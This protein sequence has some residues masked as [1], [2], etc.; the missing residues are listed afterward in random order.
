MILFIV[1]IIALAIPTRALLVHPDFSISSTE[2]YATIV[3]LYCGA[4]ALQMSLFTYIFLWPDQE[5]D[6]DS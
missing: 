6:K 4:L 1:S 2:G 3:A 5:H